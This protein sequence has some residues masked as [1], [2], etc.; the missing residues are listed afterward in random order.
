MDGNKDSD[1]TRTPTPR[2]ANAG[3][4]AS[5]RADRLTQ[6]RVE[7]LRACREREWSA[8]RW[9][10][11]DRPCFGSR[12]SPLSPGGSPAERRRDRTRAA[13]TVRAGDGSR[14]RAGTTSSVGGRSRA[15][16]A[17][18]QRSVRSAGAN[19]ALRSPRSWTWQSAGGASDEEADFDEEDLDRDIL[20]F[21][22]GSS[23][24]FDD[25]GFEGGAEDLR[26]GL[27]ELFRAAR[28]PKDL[29]PVAE[30]WCAQVG[31]VTMAEV[32]EFAH[33]LERAL[34][35]KLL[36]QRRYRAITANRKTEAQRQNR[37]TVYDDGNQH[38]L[39]PGLA[40]LLRDSLLPE[41]LKP[42]EAWVEEMG[43]VSLEELIHCVDELEE[44]LQLKVMDRQRLRKVMA[45]WEAAAAGPAGWAGAPSATAPACTA[46]SIAD[47]ED[48]LGLAEIFGEAE[49]LHLIPAAREWCDEMGVR[50]VEEVANVCDKLERALGLQVMEQRRLRS[51]LTNNVGRHALA[52]ATVDHALPGVSEILS[53]ARLSEHLNA[54]LE[55]CHGMGASSIEEVGGY[56]EVLG[57]H[58][59]LKVME[60]RRLQ[61]AYDAFLGVDVQ[62]GAQGNS[63]DASR[64]S[65]V[66]AG[67]EESVDACNDTLGGNSA[68]PKELTLREFLHDARLVERKGPAEAWCVEMGVSLVEDLAALH[69]EFIGDMNLRPMEVTR[70]KAALARNFNG[71]LVSEHAAPLSPLPVQER[72]RSRGGG[73][74]GGAS[75]STPTTPNTSLIGSP[76]EAP[77]GH[78]DWT[79]EPSEVV[80]GLR[81]LL[82]EARLEPYL[83]G[84]QAW[85]SK[86]GAVLLEEV[87][88]SADEIQEHLGLRV[89]EV[90]RFR[91]AVS[92][93]PR[94]GAAARA[95]HEARLAMAEQRRREKQAAQERELEQKRRE[96]AAVDE[97]IAN[98]KREA[99]ELRAELEAVRAAS[100]EM[101]EHFKL[102]QERDSQK[103]LKEHKQ[104]LAITKFQMS[105]R[106]VIAKRKEEEERIAAA[107]AKA[108]A[109]G[110]KGKKK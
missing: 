26:E 42:T 34:G 83:D 54:A 12:A 35:L 40:Q 77:D 95:D 27:Q 43:V 61:K 92:A 36:E 19:S 53:T 62:D 82:M 88:E 101:K 41:L 7:A 55:W 23:L 63:P 51:A 60:Q 91:A 66:S 100:E 109:K 15:A 73:G 30:A 96:K 67:Q 37:G 47:G 108:K 3:S 97:V 68:E 18:S 99:D 81:E 52:V 80:F 4:R 16:T 106:H 10:D 22:R 45:T 94:I 79:V 71:V 58:L 8:S 24:S 103:L 50:T 46:G 85:C 98:S 102:A 93:A 9:S 5:P 74:G 49:L 17:V 44:H 87:A 78:V 84:L 33:E 29:L 21:E 89:S 107:K 48:P 32:L 31:A 20:T 104:E 39:L 105:V 65:G 11:E 69:E 25:L 14:S 86:A 76:E 6:R 90:R 13:G 72:A 2:G 57:Q 110:K 28:L 75:R 56:L 38:E 70:F 59:G 1:E 64:R